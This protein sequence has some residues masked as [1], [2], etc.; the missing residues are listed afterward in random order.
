M[1]SGSQKCS[2]SKGNFTCAYVP[3]LQLSFIAWR[4]AKGQGVGWRGRVELPWL[5]APSQGY[6]SSLKKQNSRLTTASEVI[7]PQ[8]VE[9][10]GRTL[11]LMPRKEE[12]REKGK[13]LT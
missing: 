3:H 5:M 6:E 1:Y 10:I 11:Y 13:K 7:S 9:V 4:A 2:L 8:G 12:E